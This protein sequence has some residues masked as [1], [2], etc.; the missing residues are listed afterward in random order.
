MNEAIEVQH[1]EVTIRTAIQAG[2][3]QMMGSGAATPGGGALGSGSAVNGQ[4]GTG[5]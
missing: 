2:D 4:F 3:D 1:D 5:N